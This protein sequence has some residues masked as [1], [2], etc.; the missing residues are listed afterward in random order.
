MGVRY[1]GWWERSASRRRLRSPGAAPLPGAA[2]PAPVW[3]PGDRAESY[4]AGQMYTLA[5]VPPLPGS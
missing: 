1:E 2:Q 3:H 5:G 4:P